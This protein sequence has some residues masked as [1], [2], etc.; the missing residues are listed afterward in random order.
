MTKVWV[1]TADIYESSYGSEMAIIG[2]FTAEEKLDEYCK[3]Y[4]IKEKYLSV[5]TS[6]LVVDLPMIT[7]IGGY[8]EWQKKNSI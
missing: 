1:L 4:K 5:I 7:K 2:V 3:A 8:K 6:C